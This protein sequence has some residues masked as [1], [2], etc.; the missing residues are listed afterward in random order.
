MLVDLDE[1]LLLRVN[2]GTVPWEN[3]DWMV[4][5]NEEGLGLGF[6]GNGWPPSVSI[7]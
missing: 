6:K 2:K 1:E 3:Y 7:W 4:N 5:G